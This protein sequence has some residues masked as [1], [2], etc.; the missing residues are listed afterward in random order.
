[1]VKAHHGVAIATSMSASTATSHLVGRC[2]ALARLR[3]SL[4]SHYESRKQKLLME[5]M[6]SVPSLETLEEG[7]DALGELRSIGFLETEE[8]L[9]QWA[10]HMFSMH[11]APVGLSAAA[12]AN[13]QPAPLGWSSKPS[14]CDPSDDS[15]RLSSPRWPR[16][17]LFLQWSPRATVGKRSAVRGGADELL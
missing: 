4:G 11:R 7:A 17:R 3:G 10:D 13:E 14:R 2:R 15:R 5:L 16:A 1:M 9:A 6:A 8:E 12:R